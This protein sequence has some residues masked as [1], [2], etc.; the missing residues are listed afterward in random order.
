MLG[1]KQIPHSASLRAGS[2]GM[3]TRKAAKAKSEGDAMLNGWK[4]R[5]SGKFGHRTARVIAVAL[6]AAGA[7]SAGVAQEAK[8]ATGGGK[9]K[10]VYLPIPGFD[11]TSIDKAVDPCNDFYKFA[12]GKFAA[13]HPIP[14]DQPD[15]DQFYALYNVNTQALN[16]IL[17]KAAAGGTGRS[18]DA[19]K[20][21]DYYDACMNTDL[22]EKKGLAPLQP[23]LNEIDALKSKAQ[24]AELMG[25]LQ[26]FGVDA[27]FGYG[28]KPDIQDGNKK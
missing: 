18:A 2:S 23:V 11:T 16:G 15:V 1:G 27:F 22:I 26:R 12:C 4:L 6:V 8:A 3:T 10:E 9:A 19:Q 28:E 20:I 25:K 24:L 17:N 21:G 5:M 13:N 7:W 14:A